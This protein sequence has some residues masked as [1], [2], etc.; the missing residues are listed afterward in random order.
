[1]SGGKCIHELHSNG[2]KFQSCTFHPGYSQLLI[3]GG[4]Q[5][6]RY[7]MSGSIC[8]SKRHENSK[9]V[10]IDVIATKLTAKR[11]KLGARL[12]TLEVYGMEE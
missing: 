9:N 8:S 10:M 6:Y 12:F 1:M 5:V 4:Y 7:I 11:R 2:N 3:I